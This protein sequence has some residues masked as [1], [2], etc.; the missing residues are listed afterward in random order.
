MK[1]YYVEKMDKHILKVK[2]EEDKC[3]I[4]LKENNVKKIIDKMKK[5]NIENVVLEKDLYERVDFIN[6]LNANEIRIFDGKWLIKYL[7]LEIL[8]YVV[9]KSE[10][11]KQDTEIAITTN[12]INDLAIEIIRKLSKQYKRLTIVTNHIDKLRKI[13]REIYEKEGILIIV[14]NNIKQSLSKVPIILNLDFNKEVLNRYRIYEKAIIINI[15]GNMKINNR[16]FNGININD[17]EI[18]VGKQENIWRENFDKYREKDLLE[19][20]L[21]VRDTFEHIRNRISENDIEIKEIYGI[22]GKIERF[23]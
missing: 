8:D 4:R 6:A 16:R 15:E 14:S 13:E 23:S 7:S 17:Y 1:T 11:K 18:G 10:R 22:N 20:K 9:K 2:I 5:N 12:E 21:Y 19:A 3:K